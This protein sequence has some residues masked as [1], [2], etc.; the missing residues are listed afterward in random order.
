MWAGNWREGTISKLD[1]EDGEVARFPA[2]PLPY[3]FVRD[4]LGPLVYGMIFDGT[5]VWTANSH[6]GTISRM[7]LD[8]TVAASYP[9]G[10]GVARME[11]DGANIWAT[12][13]SDDTVIKITLPER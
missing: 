9:A 13:T 2:G 3:D 1:P 6:E 7:N 8:G 5:H 4:S 10:A 11:F 12:N